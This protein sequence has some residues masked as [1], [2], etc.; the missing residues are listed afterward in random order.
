[1]KTLIGGVAAIVLILSLCTS[2]SIL[3]KGERSPG[4]LRLVALHVPDVIQED[5]PYDAMVTFQSDEKPEIK[6]ICF[7]WVAELISGVSPSLYCYAYEVETNQP[8]G[9]ACTRWLAEGQFAQSSPSFCVEAKDIRFDSS[10]RFLVKLRF[11][12]VKLFYNKLEC[13]AEYYKNGEL[14]ETNRVSTKIK[15]EN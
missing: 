8:T 3:P 9:S 10:E 14:K 15:V 11:A 6:R 5:L 1:M 2:C 13:Y 12:N 7:K 4:D